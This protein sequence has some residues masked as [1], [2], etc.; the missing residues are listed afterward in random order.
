[1]EETVVI[2]GIRV[3]GAF[4]VEGNECWMGIG[5][6]SH[7]RRYRIGRLFK[8]DG[9]EFEVLYS[10]GSLCGIAI[11]A[12]SGYYYLRHHGDK[13]DIYYISCGDTPF[14]KCE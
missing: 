12:M 9:S 5:K 8:E 3:N 4:P 6:N 10:D 14:R 1:M 11:L 13:P 2:N 7:H